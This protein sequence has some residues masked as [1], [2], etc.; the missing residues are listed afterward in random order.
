MR[1]LPDGSKEAS[2]ETSI[3]HARESSKSS[4]RRNVDG[5]EAEFKR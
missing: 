1:A 5:E 2:L 3:V 4:H